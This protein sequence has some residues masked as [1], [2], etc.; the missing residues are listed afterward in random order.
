MSLA[1]G[2]AAFFLLGG[3]SSREDQRA[4]VGKEKR[5][6]ARLDTLAHVRA[7]CATPVIPWS[8]SV[9]GDRCRRSSAWLACIALAVLIS[10]PAFAQKPPPAERALVYSSYEQ[11]T[12]DDVLRSL[13]ATPATAP[14]DRTIE[15]IDIVPLDVAEGGNAENAQNAPRA[16]WFG[17][18][19]RRTEAI[20]RDVVNSLHFTSRKSVIARELLL[21]QGERY[22]QVLADDTIR[23]LRRLP[24]LSAVLV[25]AT[26]GSAP[27]RVGVVV[28]T[29]DVWSLRL[30]WDVQVTPGGVESFVAQ[31]AEWNFLGTHQTLNGYF[32]YEPS[33]YTFGLGYTVPRLGTSR[34]ALTAGVDVVLNRA[35]GDPEGSLG[36]LVVGQ[37]I[38]SGLTQWAWDASS[39]WNDYTYRLYQDAQPA[40][41]GD[42]VTGRSVPYRWHVH[43]YTMALDLT[44][45]LGWDTKHDFTFGAGV[46]LRR[47]RTDFSGADPTTVADF[48]RTNVPVSDTRVGP[49]I[50]YHTYTK[51]YVRV[52]DFDTLALQEDYRLGHDVV[53]RA[54]P[55]FR[56]LGATRDVLGLSGAAQYTVALRDGLFSFSFESTVEPEVDRIADAWVSPTAHV[57]SP[58]VF[59]LGRLV[60]DATA[61]YRPRNYLNRINYIGG[62]DRLRGYPTQFFRGPNYVVYNVELRSRPVEILT[63]QIGAVAFFDAG[64]AFAGASDFSMYQSVGGGIRALFPWLD[65]LVFRADLGFPLERPLL[66]PADSR[67]PND[68][69][70]IAPLAFFISFG[71]AFSTPSVSPAAVLPTGQ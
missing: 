68:R 27:D 69:A 62:G 10:L 22:Q 65:R 15:R 41:Y 38:Y 3:D 1:N 48:V 71:Q 52:I 17:T 21:R 45:S 14:E 34:V 57:V 63:C 8:S 6:P 5:L 12:I 46:D 51:R 18:A 24:Q 4:D 33:T 42:R 59:G 47:F 23:N 54:Y 40:T 60:V 39:S 16:S 2:T 11:R 29:K 53:L 32:L 25:V 70:P 31:P 50:R 61:L 19:I 26:E 7:P 20:G 58:T 56:A 49:S 44:R 64:D 30:N 55:S 67:R 9:T 43:T 28:I 13:H 37:P 66:P 35:S 36:S